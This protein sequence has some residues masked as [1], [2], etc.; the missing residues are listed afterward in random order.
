[1]LSASEHKRREAMAQAVE[2][3][4]REPCIPEQRLERPATDIVTVEGCAYQCGENEAMILPDSVV[5]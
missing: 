1:M 3:Y 4:V 2:R 5:L